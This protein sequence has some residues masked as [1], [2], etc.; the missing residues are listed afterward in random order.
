MAQLVVAADA[1]RPL[2]LF[3][4][5]LGPA[6]LHFAIGGFTMM[7]ALSIASW[8]LLVGAIGQWAFYG[9]LFPRLPAWLVMGA[10][11]VPWLIVL[12]ISFCNRAP[13]GPGPFRR[14]LV[15]AMCW[16]GILAVLAEVLY[17]WIQ[18]APR[19]HF[20]LIVARVLMY[21]AGAASFFVFVRACV[22][23]CRYQ[24]NPGA[25]PAA[26]PNGGPTKHL[27]NS[28]GDGGPPSVR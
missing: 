12:T 22:V 15:F 10:L 2:R 24:V 28:R 5:S 8:G 19:G 7:G 6:R 18:P 3:S 17:W 9:R 20:S 23:L 1:G 25:E 26:S 4:L 16:Y 11:F 27:G 13:F 14:C 21:C